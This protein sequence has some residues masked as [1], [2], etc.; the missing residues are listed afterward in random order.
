[1]GRPRHHFVMPSNAEL[2]RLFRVKMTT[3]DPLS[4]EDLT[5]ARQTRMAL[6][7]ELIKRRPGSYPQRWLAQRLGVTSAPSAPITSLF[8]STAAPCFW[9]H[10]STGKPSSACP[11]MKPLQGAFLQTRQGKKYPALRIIASQLLA[12]GHSLSSE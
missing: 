9:K 8:P 7:R 11:S 3:S 2:C 12:N 5:S 6:H 4:R 10:P 1:M